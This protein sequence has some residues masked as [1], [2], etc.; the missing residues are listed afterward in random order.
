MPRIR[1]IKPDFWDSRGTAAASLR[2]RLFFIAMWN[3][4]DDWG[5]GDANPRRLLGFAFPN[6]ESSEV[7]PRNFR[8]LAEE[9]TSCF[10]VAWYSVGG[11]EFYSIPS[12]EEHQRTEKKA[13]RSNP[14]PDQAD[15]I[16]YQRVAEIPTLNRG[17][18]HDGRGKGEVGSRKGEDDI[19]P[20]NETTY[21]RGPNDKDW[22]EAAH[23]V[24]IKDL[25]EL[26]ST[27]ADTLMRD[28]SLLEA[29]V[30]AQEFG[31]LT[32]DPISNLGGY[33]A[34]ACRNTPESICDFDAR[35]DLGVA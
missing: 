21:V 9:V 26:R 15:C 33:V 3:W 19:S 6:D 2:A 23:E 22:I 18:R 28:M 29:F 4:A 14:G 12:W 25:A 24:G 10:D 16:L 1:T 31:K 7:E 35:V 5:V 17:N 32:L 30:F 27:L 8:R 13:K 11:R 20:V 34:T